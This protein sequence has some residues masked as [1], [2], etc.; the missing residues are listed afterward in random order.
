MLGAVILGIQGGLNYIDLR[1]N[2][3]AASWGGMVSDAQRVLTRQPWLIVPSGLTPTLV[4]MSLMLV[5][6]GLRDAAASNRSR[7]TRAETPAAR[8]TA[9]QGP[10]A[11]V[12]TTAA[13]SVRGLSVSFSGL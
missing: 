13:L 7:P 3:L 8:A 4:I 1:V 12:D 9:D 10:I 6:D 2:P 5:A 11:P